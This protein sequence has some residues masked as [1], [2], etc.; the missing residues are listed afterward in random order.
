M[1]K[2]SQINSIYMNYLTPLQ[3]WRI[4]DLESLRRECDAEPNYH[5]F[6][7]IIR[8]MEKE[9]IIES[10]KHRFNGKKYIYFSSF[11]ERLIASTKNPTAISKDFVIHDMK[12]TEIANCFLKRDWVD[13]VE[14]EHELTNKRDFR[15]TYKVIPDALMKINTATPKLKIAL[16]IELTQ[17]QKSRISS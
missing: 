11:G 2:I 1:S 14:L 9:K 13:E 8:K 4:M 17:K 5:H 10:F 7:R 12:V 16:E 3:K 15:Q 6:A